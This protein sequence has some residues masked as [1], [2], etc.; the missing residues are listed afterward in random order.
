MSAW[1][2]KFDLHLLSRCGSG[3][4]PEIEFSCGWDRK[5]PRGGD[6][7][8][9]SAL[10]GT[11][12]LP[13]E[14]PVDHLSMTVCRKTSPNQEVETSSS[15]YC[16][17]QA[18]YHWKP[19]STISPWQH[20]GRLHL[21]KRWRQAHLLCTVLDRLLLEA[22]VDHLSMTACRETLLNQEVETSLSPLYCR[23]QATAG[24]H[25]R[26]SLHDSV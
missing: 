11:G 1:D 15:L 12:Y 20:V 23:G 9:S 8:I 10:F 24:S 17:G 26:P 22:P 4:V 16:W 14:A 25:Y 19:L 5:E 6:K 2:S 7:L 3:C 13:L 21:T 18:T